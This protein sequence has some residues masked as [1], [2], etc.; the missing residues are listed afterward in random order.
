MI[1]F[2]CFCHSDDS[3]SLTP[4]ILLEISFFCCRPGFPARRISRHLTYIC[5]I[6]TAAAVATRRFLFQL[7]RDTPR[8]S[9]FSRVYPYGPHHHIR[10]YVPLAILSIL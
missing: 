4:L 1:H 10:H 8:L 7:L 5:T 2:L 6:T 3:C 9:F